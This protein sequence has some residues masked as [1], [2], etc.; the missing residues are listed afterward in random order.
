MQLAQAHKYKSNW[1]MDFSPFF[2]IVNHNRIKEKFFSISILSKP[3]TAKSFA[4]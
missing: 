2:Q 4:R 1:Q 3:S